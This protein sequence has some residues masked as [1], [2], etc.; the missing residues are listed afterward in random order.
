[1]AE[2]QENIIL[3]DDV[4]IRGIAVLKQLLFKMLFYNRYVLNNT[5]YD[6]NML[7]R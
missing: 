3:N 7:G 4:T 1:M 2:I 6:K 5:Y